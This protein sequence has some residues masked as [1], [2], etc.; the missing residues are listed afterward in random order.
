M[1]SKHEHTWKKKSYLMTSVASRRLTS[2][3]QQ[4]LNIYNTS[5]HIA[6]KCSQG[7]LSK[8]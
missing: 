8:M 7:G 3:S 1:A 5:S 6:L 4:V 2:S